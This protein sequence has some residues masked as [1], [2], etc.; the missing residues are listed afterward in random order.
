MI[1]PRDISLIGVPTDVGGAHP[2]CSMAPE[3]L[4]VA[5]IDL[6]LRRLGH[7]VTDMGN[8]AGPPNPKAAPV[9]GY[10]HLDEVRQ[11]CRATRD[12][13]YESL[14]AGRL[15]ITMG[16]DHSVTIG[17][18]AG[19][20]RWCA[21]QQRPLSLLWLDA[22]AD[23]NT[24]DT[25]PSGNVHGMPV[26]IVAGQGPRTLVSL[27]T[28]VPMVQPSRI[29]QVGLRSIDQ[30]EK[31]LVQASGVQIFDMRQ[32]DESGIRHVMDIVLDQLSGL[33]GHV[34]VSL[35]ADFLDPAVAPGVAVPVPGGPTYREAQLCMEMI[36]DSG[37]MG[38][39]DLMEVN[40]AYDDR[41]R[42]ATV[43]VELVASLFGQQILSRRQVVY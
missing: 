5:G 15:P 36:Y 2:G 33:G 40:P 23:F 27:A 18:I 4:R 20:A 3:A 35:D 14:A 31:P 25:S 41:N 24:P 39:L 11:W 13:V 32:V 42:T 43:M 16:G 1:D 34:H 17:S 12:L 28:V 37:L 6:A 19:I 38:S 30:S 8:V 9:D 10:R 22:H 26:A 29:L 21:K 7:R